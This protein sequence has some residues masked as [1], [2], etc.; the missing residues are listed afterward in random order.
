MTAAGA[1]TADVDVLFQWLRN[2]TE[3]LQQVHHLRG[4]GGR[5]DFQ[6]TSRGVERDTR[7]GIER[8]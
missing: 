5:Q 4:G 1:A 7:L 3:F 8:L 6:A 2:D